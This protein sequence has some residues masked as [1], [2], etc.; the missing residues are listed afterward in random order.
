M[1]LQEYTEHGHRM[2]YAGV[3]SFLGFP[4]GGRLHSN[5]L[6]STS[7]IPGPSNYVAPLWVCMCFG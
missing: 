5:L 3:P 6:A 2:T 4:V 7:T 1:S